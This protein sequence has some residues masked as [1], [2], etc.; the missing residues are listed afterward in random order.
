M[1]GCAHIPMVD[2]PVLVYYTWYDLLV[3]GMRFPMEHL[4]V[5][6]YLV[7]L[8]SLNVDL[9]VHVSIYGHGSIAMNIHHVVWS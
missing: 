7:F 6:H 3:Y 9:F 2:I 8:Y 4:H 1:V 5:L